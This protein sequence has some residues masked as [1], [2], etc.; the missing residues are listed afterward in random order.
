MYLLV[1]PPA[2]Q[3]PRCPMNKREALGSLAYQKPIV[4]FLLSCHFLVELL[5]PSILSSYSWLNC[6]KGIPCQQWR[7]AI[8]RLC[9][10]TIPMPHKITSLLLLFY[11]YLVE[12][13]DPSILSSYSWLNCDKGIPCQKWKG[14]KLLILCNNSYLPQNPM[15]QKIT[16]LFLLFCH[17]LVELLDSS[18]LSSY[19]WL[20][21]NSFPKWRGKKLL[22]LYHN[23]NVQQNHITATTKSIV[24]HQHKE[25]ANFLYNLFF[26]F[27][28]EMGGR[29]SWLCC[30]TIQ[31][32]QKSTDHYKQ[33]NYKMTHKTI[34]QIL[35]YSFH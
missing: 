31:M 22:I 15:S 30:G 25:G 16:S 13:L 33:T 1:V 9:C 10:A 14:K 4:P 27:C 19:S 26:F 21:W 8:N 23:S 32:L 20:N 24:M 3:A 7:G 34:I 5:D 18:I 35:Y 17:S 28:M 29:G 12:L 2:K 6:E 11:H